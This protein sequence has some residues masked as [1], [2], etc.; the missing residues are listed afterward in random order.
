MWF[1]Y[2][3]GS[4]QEDPSGNGHATFFENSPYPFWVYR[5]IIIIY[6]NPSEKIKKKWPNPNKP[7]PKKY[8]RG[9]HAFGVM[10]GRRMGNH[11]TLRVIAP[12]YGKDSKRF[13]LRPGPRNCEGHGETR[14]LPAHDLYRFHHLR[15][16]PPRVQGCPALH[17]V[18][19]GMRETTDDRGPQ[20]VD[21]RS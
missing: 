9:G 13:S 16:E 21:R 14:P 1:S 17:V 11:H 19:G 10:A 5:P 4:P 18:Q 2:I 15:P 12:P 3:F 6:K 20:T 7:E 8:C